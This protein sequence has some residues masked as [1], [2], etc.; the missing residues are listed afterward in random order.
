MHGEHGAGHYLLGKLHI[1]HFNGM[2]GILITDTDRGAVLRR[3]LRDHEHGD[4]ILGQRRE[5]AAVDA[6]DTHHRKTRHRD[7]G[8]ALDA[9]YALNHAVVVLYLLL[10]QR[11][12]MLRVEGV[13]HLDGDVLHAHRIDGGRIDDLG[14]AR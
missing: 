5:D 7:K 10:D 2:V 6:D 11:T 4:A 3:G 1:E 9:R 8:S 14:R 12:W 13:L